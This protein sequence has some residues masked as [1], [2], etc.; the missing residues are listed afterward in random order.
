MMNAT[1]R[2][3]HSE[4]YKTTAI[5]SGKKNNAAKF[6]MSYKMNAKTKVTTVEKQELSM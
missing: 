1:T 2:I 5:K 6:N 4:C 3:K